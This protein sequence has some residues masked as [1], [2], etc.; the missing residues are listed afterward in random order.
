MK[1]IFLITTG[2]WLC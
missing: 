2:L 1:Y